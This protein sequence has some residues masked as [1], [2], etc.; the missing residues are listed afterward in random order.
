MTPRKVGG[1]KN[2]CGDGG[3]AKMAY[4]R[5]LSRGLVLLFLKLMWCCRL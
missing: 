1:Y 5:V 4:I 2:G 3:A